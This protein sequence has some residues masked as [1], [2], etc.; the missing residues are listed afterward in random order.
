[1]LKIDYYY[2]YQSGIGAFYYSINIQYKH[3][4][5]FQKKAKTNTKSSMFEL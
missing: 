5:S 2:Y 3:I 1:M 4:L